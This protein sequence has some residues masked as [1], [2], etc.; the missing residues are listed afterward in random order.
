[1]PSRSRAFAMV[2]A[3]AVLLL[4]GLAARGVS[5]PSRG[6]GAP[7]QTDAAVVGLALSAGQDR[8]RGRTILLDPGHNG[9]NAAAAAVISRKVDAGGAEKECDTAGAET[10]DGYPEHAFAFDVAIRAAAL[11]RGRGA[12]VVLTRPD[13]SGVGPCINERARIG[14]DVHADAAVSVHA[15]G[16]PP[17]GSGFHIIAPSLG[18]DGANAVI[19]APSARLADALRIG[20]EHDTGEPRADYVADAGLSFRADLGGLN[21]SRVPKVFIECANMRNPADATRVSDATWRQHAAQGVAD[22]ITLFLPAP[23]S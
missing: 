10:N 3:A 14:N 22:G 5:S 19:L 21:L 15:D 11:L 12:T 13:D 17:T 7:P 18:P 1:M 6:S 9:G 8:L 20:F 2:L 16:G 4:V 23:P